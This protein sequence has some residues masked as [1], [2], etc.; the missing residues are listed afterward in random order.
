[1]LKEQILSGEKKQ[2]IRKLRKTPFKKGDRLDLYF[3]LRKPECESLGSFT[4]TDA[5][6]IRIYPSMRSIQ[7]C[8]LEGKP[9]TF[10]S[11]L[12]ILEVAQRDG[13]KNVDALFTALQGMHG[14]IDNSQVWQVIRW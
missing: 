6:Y 10:M 4:C 7:L 9:S 13:F 12:E 11:G 8:D 14:P 3:H 5:F 2:T 1:M